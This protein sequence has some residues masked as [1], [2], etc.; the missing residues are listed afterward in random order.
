M[1]FKHGHSQ[2]V[3]CHDLLLHCARIL[4]SKY[5]G[6]GALTYTEVLSLTSILFRNKIR[7]TNLLELVAS[8]VVK[9]RNQ[10]TLNQITTS[11]F[12]IFLM[13]YRSPVLARIL[14]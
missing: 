14:F 12:Q 7:D 9:A 8:E 6:T 5:C 13:G 1:N 4:C 11:V 10:M 2:L 3:Y